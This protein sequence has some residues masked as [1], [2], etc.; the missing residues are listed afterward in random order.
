MLGGYHYSF[1]DCSSYDYMGISVVL[2]LVSISLH[3]TNGS[4]LLCKCQVLYLLLFSLFNF[5][6][7]AQRHRRQ[8]QFQRAVSS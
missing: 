1:D 6:K 5:R 7:K 8:G 3:V 4:Y 2:C